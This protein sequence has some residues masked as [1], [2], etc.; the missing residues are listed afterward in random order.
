MLKFIHDL[1]KGQG[2]LY[3]DL[4]RIMSALALLSAFVAV[5]WNIHLKQPIDLG[6]AGF[7][8]GLG[9]LLT[10]AGALIALKDRAR[11]PSQ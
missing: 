6:P 8:G 3:W 7:L 10:A 11:G 5:G 9:A 1:F 4:G 2:N